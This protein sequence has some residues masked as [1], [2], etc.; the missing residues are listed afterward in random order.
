MFFALW[1]CRFM[2]VT[3]VFSGLLQWVKMLHILN[4]IWCLT[5]DRRAAAVISRMRTT[6]INRANRLLLLRAEHVIC[7]YHRC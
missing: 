2:Y 4:D 6:I 1:L 5:H 7:G 3:E